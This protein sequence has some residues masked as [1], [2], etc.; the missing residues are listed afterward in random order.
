MNNPS[1]RA[2]LITPQA[3]SEPA[4]SYT[5]IIE[6]DLIIAVDGGLKRCLELNLTP[7]ILIGDLDSL[8]EDVLAKLPSGCEKVIH[9]V[10]KDETDT[11]L[12]VEYCIE[13]NIV[14]IFICND[15]SGRF[16]HALALIQNLMQAHQRVIKATLVS[17]K[18]LIT[19]LSES[20][21]L[22]YPVGTTLSLISITEKTE[23][24]SSTGLKYP[25]DN[26]T[27]Y[28]WQSRGISNIATEPHQHICKK[29]GT[30]ILL[31][32]LN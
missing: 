30:A 21:T 20:V 5:S 10:E 14:E 1:R 26:L 18:Q 4:I 25:L 23:F 31:A 3:P 8:T 11:Q 16:D 19:I 6:S 15:L 2:W 32:T 13:H 9:P 24:V 27:L 17:Q 28:N 12:A 22:S 29:L 7:N